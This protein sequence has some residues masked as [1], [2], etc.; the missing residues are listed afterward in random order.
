MAGV[1][2]EF[3]GNSAIKWPLGRIMLACCRKYAFESAHHSGIRL[4]TQ[5]CRS[6]AKGHML[7]EQLKAM[8]TSDSCRRERPTTLS[9]KPS[10]LHIALHNA[11]QYHPRSPILRTADSA[12]GIPASTIRASLHD[13]VRTPAGFMRRHACDDRRPT[14]R[15][16]C[17]G[18]FGSRRFGVPHDRGHLK[19][20]PPQ[21]GR[22]VLG[23]RNTAG[24]RVHGE[25]ERRASAPDACADRAW[26]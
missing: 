19:V 25:S 20:R 15:G 10:S 4:A 26:S 5:E 17:I 8:P 12:R 16:E 2:R 9:A 24:H 18:K 13:F 21:A 3:A 11:I 6:V 1:R 23:G 7:L 22:K 14:C